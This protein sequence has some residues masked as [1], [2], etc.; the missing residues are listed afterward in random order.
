[1]KEYMENIFKKVYGDSEGVRVFFA[2]G[3]VNLIGE[4]TDYNGGHV[5]PCALTLG[6]YAAIR[7]RDD[8]LIHLYSDNITNCL[9]VERECGDYN[10]YNKG[11]S[12]SNYPYGI[13]WSLRENGIDITNGY[14]IVYYGNIPAGA[15]LSSSASIEVL[16]VYMLSVMEKFDMS[17]TD[18]ALIG[19]FSENNYNKMNCGIMDQ[20]TSAMGKDGHAIFLDTAT[21]DYEYAPLDLKDKKIIIINSN[22]KHSLG[23]SKYNER[24]SE[25][26]AALS[27]LQTDLDI[28]TLGELTEEEFDNNQMLIKDEIQRKRAKHAVYE[29]QRTIKAYNALKE[30]D[31]D[32]FGKLMVDSHISLRDDYEVSCNELDVIVEEGLKCDGVI[33]IR[34]TGGGFGGSCV[35]IVDA[36]KEELVVKQIGENYAK[37]TGREAS[38][39][40]VLAGRGPYEL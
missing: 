2:P 35:S 38:F 34:M 15:G 24:R 18:M 17:L 7:K 40:S 4:H 5:F 10:I 9:V 19:Q 36:D 14:D 30:N 22:V 37:R 23:S 21:L 28:E 27:A 25:S 13:F 39:Y 20:F 26:E 33:G 31:I 1:M 12:W 3:R 16:T 6:T 8:N 29:N 32:T 11:N